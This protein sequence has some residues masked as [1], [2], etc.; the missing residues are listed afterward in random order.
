[1]ATHYPPDLDLLQEV[2]SSKKTALKTVED[3][4]G[5]LRLKM[6]YLHLQEQDVAQVSAVILAIVL[7][8]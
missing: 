1:M 4:I 2:I 8:S 7:V 3:H 5:D 6:R